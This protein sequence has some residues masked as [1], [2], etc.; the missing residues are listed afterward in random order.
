MPNES[1]T[2]SDRDR[3]LDEVVTAYLKAVEAG[4]QPD[5]Q[6]WLERYPDLASE[7]SGFFAGQKQVAALAGVDTVGPAQ[8]RGDGILGKVRYIGDYELLEEIA[9]GGMGVVYKARQVSLK[10]LVALKMILA[11]EYAGPQ[12][13]TRFRTE[14]QAVASLQHPNI[15]QI[16]EVGSHEGHPYFSLEYCGGSLA[17]KLNGT[18]LP[19]MPAARMTETLARAMHVAHQAGI[20]HRDLKPANVLLSADGSL[21]IADF[22]LAKK[23][24]ETEAGA[25]ASP[26]MTVS[27]AIVGTPSYMAPEQAAGK[28]KE[29]GP[30]AD[31]YALGAILYEMLT[32]RPPFRAATPLDTLMMV[33]A[34]DP[35]PPSQLNPTPRDLETICLKCLQKDPRKRYGSAQALADDLRR[36]Q[37]GEPILARPTSVAEKAVKWVRR[38]PGVAG[39]IAAVCL[40][41]ALGTAAFAWSYGI[42]L[43][44][45]DTALEARTKEAQERKRAEENESQA[46][47]ARVVA[48]ERRLAAELAEKQRARELLRA[49]SLLYCFQTNQAHDCLL[50]N[51]LIGCRQALDETRWDLRGADYDYLAKA[52]ARKTRIFRAAYPGWVFSHVVSADGKRLYSSYNKEIK[53]WDLE[54]GKEILTLRGHTTLV[55]SLAIS[56]DGKRLYSGSHAG[57]RNDAEIKVWDVAAGKEMGSLRGHTSTVRIL[58]LSADGKR[59][60][61]AGDNQAIRVWNLDIGEVI[62]ALSFPATCLALSADGKRLFAGSDQE[63][64]WWNLD[65]GAEMLPLRGHNFVRSLALSADGKRLYSG[66]DQTIKVW[67]VEAGKELLTLPGTYSVCSLALSPDGKRLYAVSIQDEFMVW[68]VEAGKETLLKREPG[69]GNLIALSADGKRL[70]FSNSGKWNPRIPLMEW[71]LEVGKDTRTLREHPGGVF[72]LSAG[73]KRLFSAGADRTIKMWDLD[74][75]AEG[76]KPPEPTLT[77]RG[78]TNRV[79]SLALS[80]DGKRL[81]SAALQEIKVWDL[82]TGKEALTLSNGGGV[83]SLALAPDGKLLFAAGKGITVWSLEEGK[84]RFTLEKSDDFTSLAVAADGKSLFSGGSTIGVWDLKQLTKDSKPEFTLSGITRFGGGVTSLAV[85]ADGKRL[86]AARNGKLPPE[87]VVDY[88]EY[89]EIGVWD[90]AAR[91]ETLTLRGHV[92]TVTCLAVTADGK[93]LFSGSADRTIKAW[94]LEAGRETLTLRQH[95]FPVTS[96][97]LAADGKQLVSASGEMGKTGEIKVWDLAADREP[98]TLFTNFQVRFGGLT[99]AADGKRLFSKALQV[100]KVWS[101]ETGKETLTLTLTLTLPKQRT[102]VIDF[103]NPALAREGK[104][105]AL[106][107]DTTIQVWDLET[108]QQVR[109]LR[110]HAHQVTS[111]ALSADGKRLVSAA[112]ARKSDPRPDGLPGEIKVWDLESGKETLTLHGKYVHQLIVAADGKRLYSMNIG[113]ITVWDLEAG[114]ETATFDTPWEVQDRA[115][116]LHTMVLSAD[117]KRLVSTSSRKA[118]PAKGMIYEIMVWDLDANKNIFTLPMSLPITSLA[119]STDGKRVFLVHAQR[120]QKDLPEHTIRVWDLETGKECLTLRGHPSSV[121]HLALTADG[122]RLFSATRDQIKIW[123]LKSGQEVLTLHSPSEIF[124]LALSADGKR[125]F[126]GSTGR[127]HVWDVEAELRA[128][129]V[130]P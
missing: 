34:N 89:G 63:I 112:N 119:L 58:A 13:L 88:D 101:L 26:A 118:D 53:V 100:F 22:G 59:L 42:A 83:S 9:R 46:I 52:L 19:A 128:A 91:R 7:L 66:G 25:S 55:Y 10:R 29:V 27:G 126:A 96:L 78:H 87:N 94:D 50:K 72:A 35:V 109:T 77:L 111:L 67:D 61:S 85:S 51:D 116:G 99:P 6:A 121:E 105:L 120:Q 47:A 17:Q 113:T 37:A 65:T 8:D 41:T 5:P 124:G 108:S 23:Q 102:D 81:C 95:A 68:N 110:G 56:S 36:F 103:W 82:E 38:R 104:W 62:N 11:G 125:L 3:R 49:D 69:Y 21:K 107:S 44:E 129:G 71:D 39:L 76:R 12:E 127:I 79:T 14:G 2:T 43:A 86:F 84:A 93:R 122:K 1:A 117:G 30:A 54:T 70:Y 31:V 90:L 123:D 98:L 20:V 24:S 48:D 33:A 130:A 75:R 28:G 64:K 15:V 106:A 80:A 73:G 97:A 40:V 115:D 74:W 4:E 16:Y 18:P 92:R 60:Y 114:K 57:E 45:R 32:G